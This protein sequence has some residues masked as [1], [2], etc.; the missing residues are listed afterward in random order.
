MA[1]TLKDIAKKSGL[2]IS[3]VSR[4]LNKKTAK[5][6]ISKETEKLVLR[7]ARDLN[8]RP[9]QLARGLRLKKTHTIGLVAPD[10]SN[11]FFAYIIKSAQGVA[12]QLG[13]TLV[14][15][16]TDESLPLEVDHV[17]LL[18]SKGVDGMVVMPVGQKCQHLET[19]VKNGVPV[20][21]VDR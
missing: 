18:W 19:L 9:N 10:L 11:P 7:T 21:M 1:V 16:D 13:Y 12:H 20:V 3:I 14:V 4:V 8:Y 15:C 2:S 17:N 6:R 5:Y